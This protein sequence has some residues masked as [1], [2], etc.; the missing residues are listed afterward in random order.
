MPVMNWRTPCAILIV[1]MAAIGAL[2]QSKPV[3]QATVCDIVNHP[4]QFEGK[5]VRVRAEAW[6]DIFRDQQFWMNEVTMRSGKLCQFLRARFIGQAY[7]GGSSGFG[8]FTGRLVRESAPL[9]LDGRGSKERLVF[10]V[11]KESDV[12]A[13][14]YRTGPNPPLQLYDKQTGAF[15][16]P[17]PEHTVRGDIRCGDARPVPGTSK[18]NVSCVETDLP[19]NYDVWS[20]MIFQP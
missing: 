11:E 15:I 6:S 7:L 4:L 8:T 14:Q 13:I 10:I 16:K 9:S 5:R 19:A 12:D 20:T 3:I 1:G 2:A 18:M 17:E